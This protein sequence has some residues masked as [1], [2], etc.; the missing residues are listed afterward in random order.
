MLVGRY[1]DAAFE[2]RTALELANGK[3]PVRQNLAVAY[4]MSDNKKGIQELQSQYGFSAD[5]LAY[6]EKL[7]QQFGRAAP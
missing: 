4:L 5:E 3:G 2:L 6:A 7:S 1:E